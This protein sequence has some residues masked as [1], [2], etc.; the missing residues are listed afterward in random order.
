MLHSIEY[1]NVFCF[2]SLSIPDSSEW[3]LIKYK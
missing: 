3:V 1:A 2:H